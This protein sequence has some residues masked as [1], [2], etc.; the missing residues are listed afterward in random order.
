M[1]GIDSPETK[2]LQL[3]SPFE[4]SFMSY[5]AREAECYGYKAFHWNSEDSDSKLYRKFIWVLS[6]QHDVLHCVCLSDT[7][8]FCPWSIFCNYTVKVL[9]LNSTLY[10]TTLM[11]ISKHYFN[12]NKPLWEIM[13]K[14][15]KNRKNP[16]KREAQ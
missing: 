1:Y 7:S 4:I 5:F 2:P 13:V 10:D 3:C 9:C 6:R 12:I 15:S 11:P 16:N 14:I 8:F